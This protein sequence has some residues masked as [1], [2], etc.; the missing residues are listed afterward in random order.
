MKCTVTE[1]R[2]EKK[3]GL[4]LPP[5]PTVPSRLDTRPGRRGSPLGGFETGSEPG[6]RAAGLRG[7]S[8]ACAPSGFPAGSPSGPKPWRFAARQIRNRG[9]GS[10]RLRSR[11]RSSV[12]P[13][14]GL[15]SAEA[16]GLPDSPWTR[17]LRL[18]LRSSRAEARSCPTRP[19]PKPCP[20]RWQRADLRPA[21]C[22]TGAGPKSVPVLIANPK[23]RDLGRFTK[24]A[25]FASAQGQARSFRMAAASSAARAF[26]PPPHCLVGQEAASLGLWLGRLS[27]LRSIVSATDRKLSRIVI[28]TKG[29]PTV[30]NEDNG[31]K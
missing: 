23:V 13:P 26:T 9:S 16:S 8:G 14:A 19:G 25:T 3:W 5:A 18:P 22:R 17:V 12:P 7:P 6:A 10:R 11:S 21:F 30:D 27:I 31:H 24:P 15:P 28:R 1:I 2:N 4:A 29:I 20:R